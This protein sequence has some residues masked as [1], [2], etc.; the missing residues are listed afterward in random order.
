M[1]MTARI[2]DYDMDVPNFIARSSE[3]M[4]THPK[5]GSKV[6]FIDVPVDYVYYDGSWYNSSGKRVDADIKKLSITI[7]DVAY[8]GV[9]DDTDITVTVP[10]GTTVTELTPVVVISDGATISPSTAQDFTNPVQY[11]VTA[12]DTTTEKTYTVTVEVETA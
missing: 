10:A 5:D 12:E 4:P 3:G 11:T 9:I 2:Y 6:T 7:S 1:I 8:N